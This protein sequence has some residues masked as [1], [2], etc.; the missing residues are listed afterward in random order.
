MSAPHDIVRLSPAALRRRAVE[1]EFLPAA[2]EVVETPPSPI[3]H[4]LAGTLILLFCLALAWACWGTVDIIATAP[5]KIVPSGQTKIVQPFEIGVIQG[6]Y[7]HDGETVKA[8]QLLVALDPTMNQ[9]EREHV[10]SDLLSAELDVARLHAALSGDAD[11][12]AGFQAPPGANPALVASQR[13]YLLDE[14]DAERAKL[15][16]L[17]AE[18]SRKQA[19][20]AT[21]A[22][23]VNKI[24][25]LIPLLQQQVDIRKTLFDDQ[26]GSKLVYIQT[27][28][29]LVEQQKELLVQKSHYQE[30]TAALAAVIET[31]RQ[32]VGD[33]RRGLLDELT[34]AETKAAGLSQD[35]IRA[36]ARTQLERLTAP[37]DG[38]VQQ[39]AVHT[40]G[41]V[42]TPAEALL[43]LVPNDRHLEIRAMVSNRDI[44]FVHSGQVA[45]IKVD[46]FPFTRYGL[47]YGTVESVS[48]DAVTPDN[49]ENKADQTAA[50]AARDN[51][52]PSPKEPDYEALV[53]VDQSDMR[54]DDNIV[55]LTP[56][57]AVT[58]EIKTG[59]RRIIS[60]LLS[61]LLRYGHDSL[62][63]R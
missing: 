22:A 3:G 18:S 17:D 16:A 8:G 51:A 35:L 14:V 5:G 53:S 33:Y 57:M 62:R 43:V 11:P 40:V 20:R 12:L 23:T 10:Q 25:A 26:F 27:Q 29:A 39:L 49:R 19:E 7:V 6:I 28:Q 4:A 55:N 60:Y 9:A 1:L 13:Q 45:D 46:T 48:A 38:V 34:K 15:A 41:G 44:G 50:A 47:L 36:E 56:G 58:V 37:V 42:V 61:P 32:T 52:N 21:A 2:L 59:S 30:A 31:R 63:E 54:I 24:E